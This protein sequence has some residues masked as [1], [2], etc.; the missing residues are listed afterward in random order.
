MVRQGEHMHR[1]DSLDG[2]RAVSILFVVSGHFT[3]IEAIPAA[4]GVSIFFAISGFIITTLLLREIE[5]TGTIDF[6]AF[7]RRRAFRLLPAVVVAILT[8]AAVQALA[9]GL[10]WVTWPRA[11][12]SLL[13]MQN[14]YVDAVSFSGPLAMH[15]SLAVEEHFYML[16]PLL[17]LAG[18]RSMGR[19]ITVCLLAA[20]LGVLMLRIATYGYMVDRY[21]MMI[22]QGTIYRSTHLR[23]DSILG[24]VM[25]A[26][27]MHRSALDQR[28][29]GGGLH[30]VFAGAVLFLA[31]RSFR[32]DWFAETL[33]FSVQT[34]GIVM[35]MAGIL[36][37]ARC[38]LLR[39]MLSLPPV[40]FVGR[41]SFS[42]YLLHEQV[43]VLAGRM[44]S[45]DAHDPRTLLLAVPLVILTAWL[46]FRL[47]ETPMIDWGRRLERRRRA[48]LGAMP[49]A[50]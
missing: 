11:M 36:F 35:L 43:N 31:V 7:Y 32:P 45:L 41:I 46:S 14:Y 27:M 8:A 50:S 44:L 18:W 42:L 12:A 19:Q 49:N 21:P 17:L 33:K 4:L 15:W 34:A 2:L 5:T 26:V 3:M 28:R 16:A 25:L 48:A 40:V 38:G 29:T 23:I 1:I 30:L 9:P 24:G 6:G 13:F 10:D 39:R 37:G 47:V 20:C 22:V